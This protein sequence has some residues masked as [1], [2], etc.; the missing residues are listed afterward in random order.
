[1]NPAGKLSGRGLSADNAL[2]T[3]EACTEFVD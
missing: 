3:A 1:L 2:F